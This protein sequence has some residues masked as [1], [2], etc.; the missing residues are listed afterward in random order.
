M[1]IVTRRFSAAP[2]RTAASTW[3]AIIDVLA[4]KTGNVRNELLKIEGLAASIISDG[5]PKNSAITIIGAGSRLR[6][7]CLYEEDGSTEDASESA[8]NWNPFE[9][10]WEIFFP[11]ETSD[12]VWVKKAFSEKGARFKAYEVGTTIQEEDGQ[13]SKARSSQGGLSIDISNL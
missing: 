2:V 4:P 5:T 3:N 13:A 10:E 8:L 7:Y 1:S 6:I 9:K 11:V 12:L